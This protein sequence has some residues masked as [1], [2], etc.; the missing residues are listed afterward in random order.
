MET[1]YP[2]YAAKS[3]QLPQANFQENAYAQ[4]LPQAKYSAFRMDGSYPAHAQQLPQA[5]FQAF[6]MD[7]SYPPPKP[8]QFPQAKFQRRRFG[9]DGSYPDYAAKPQQFPQANFQEKD[10]EIVEGLMPRG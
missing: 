5:I 10:W 3:Q 8:L 6:G 2:A 1:S 9:M 7:E 4:Q